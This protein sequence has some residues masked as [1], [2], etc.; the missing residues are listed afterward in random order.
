MTVNVFSVAK[1][2]QPVL[3]TS[4]PISMVE[5]S[6]GPAPTR[7]ILLWKPFLEPDKNK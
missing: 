7:H 1:M 2:E 6:N 3:D 5:E 4:I